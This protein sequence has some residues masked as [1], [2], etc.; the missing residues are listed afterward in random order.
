MKESKKTKKRQTESVVLETVK[1]ILDSDTIDQRIMKKRDKLYSIHASIAV[2]GMNG[3]TME[4]KA[5]GRELEDRLEYR[6]KDA[7][8][9]L[10]DDKIAIYSELLRVIK[11]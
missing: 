5:K 9:K 6:I 7:E 10:L 8:E 11:K 1:P 2:Y 3:L 4:Q